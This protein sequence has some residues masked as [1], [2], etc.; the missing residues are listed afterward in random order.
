MKEWL[1][2][3]QIGLSVLGVL[4]ALLI[5][6]CV[7]RVYASVTLWERSITYDRIL[8]W[9]LIP[10][11][12]KIYEREEEPYRIA[13]NSKG[14]RDKE[15]SYEKP[16]SAFRVV[17]LGDSFVFGSGGVGLYRTDRRLC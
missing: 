6:E 7:A 8:G 13:I 11:A 1:L 2:L 12:D 17:V 9:S 4:I 15:Y 16:A 10:N 3:R 5:L 14:L